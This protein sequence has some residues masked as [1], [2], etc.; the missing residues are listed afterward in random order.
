MSRLRRPLGTPS[1]TEFAKAWRLDP[2]R[3]DPDG[4]VLE[5]DLINAMDVAPGRYGRRGHDYRED[6]ACSRD[7]ERG[8]ISGAGGATVSLSSCAWVR[9]RLASY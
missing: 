9:Q 6:I 8:V 4:S 5:V 3:I 1:I 2:G 7:E